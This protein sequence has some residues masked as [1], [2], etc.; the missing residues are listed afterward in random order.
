[1]NNDVWFKPI[2]GTAWSKLSLTNAS[3]LAL[4]RAK[5]SVAAILKV[6]YEL[7]VLL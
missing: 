7:D 5:T 2:A 1:M 4:Y 3:L 6:A